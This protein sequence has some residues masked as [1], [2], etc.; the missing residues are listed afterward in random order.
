LSF[1]HFIDTANKKTIQSYKIRA[2]TECKT[3]LTTSIYDLLVMH[4]I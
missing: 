2:M 1:I 4:D 3:D